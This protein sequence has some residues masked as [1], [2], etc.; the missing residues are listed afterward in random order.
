[1]YIS[2]LGNSCIKIQTKNTATDTTLIFDPYKPKTGSFPKSLGPDICLFTQGK[3]GSVPLS[4]NTYVIDIPGEYEVHSI[5]I[6]GIAG[7]DNTLLF[8]IEAE[9]ISL[10][11]LGSLTDM[12]KDTVLNELEGTDILCI[13]IGGAHTLDAETAAKLVSVIEPRLVIPI[14][15]KTQGLGTE[16]ETV[17]PFLKEMGASNPEIVSK[18]RATKK[19]L[20]QEEAHLVLLEPSG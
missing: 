13:P 19:D 9:Q 11:H 15:Y 7:T 6:N 2:W 20:P 12:P 1:M 16:Y 3:E 14:C 4:P 5:F 18:Y 17:Q 8:R 10:A